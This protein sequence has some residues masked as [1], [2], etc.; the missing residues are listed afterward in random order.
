MSALRG[1][2]QLVPDVFVGRD[3]ALLQAFDF[4][5]RHAR[6]REVITRASCGEQ[7]EI[8]VVNVAENQTAGTI[9]ASAD[10]LERGFK[11][12]I[13]ILSRL[14]HYSHRIVLERIGERFDPATL[15][16]QSES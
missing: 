3:D 12:K 6:E 7:V 8:L 10:G 16:G 1:H 4:P 13:R 5:I 15:A 11:G 2:L 9:E 14:R